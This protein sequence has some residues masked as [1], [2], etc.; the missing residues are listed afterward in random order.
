ML[1]GHVSWRD[2]HG[3]RA[4]RPGDSYV[5]AQ[6][7]TLR[8]AIAFIESNAH[9]DISV[10]DIAAAGFVTVR[11]VQP[12]FRRHLGTTPMAHLRWGFSQPSCFAAHYS[13][14]RSR[15]APVGPVEPGC[16]A[17]WSDRCRVGVDRAARV[18]G[19]HGAVAAAGA[20]RAR[21]AG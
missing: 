21:G 13:G 20:G 19:G 8:R 11:A 9:R 3:E 1:N 10:A 18:G 5:A 16:G 12:A 15:G 2:R 7:D 4:Y 14:S 6:P 17:L